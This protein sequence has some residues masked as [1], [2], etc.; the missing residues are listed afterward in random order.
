MSDATRFS[1]LAGLLLS[2]PAWSAPLQITID[3][4]QVMHDGQPKAAIGYNG[5]TPGPVLHLDEGEDAV[6]QVT[7][8]LK[9]TTSIHWHGMILPFTQDGVPGFG[10]AGIAPGETFTYRFP[11][12]QNGTFWYHSHSGMQEQE[13]AYG[14]I[15]IKPKKREPFRYDRDYVVL[16]SDRHRDSGETIF[17]HL[18]AAA[19]YYNQQQSTLSDLFADMRSKGVW[20][21]LK[22]RWM[23]GDMRMSPN[24]ISDVQGYR[25]LL[26]GKT[27]DEDWRAGFN[28]GERIRLRLVNASAMTY[29]DVR[30]PGL[31]MTVVQADGTNVQPVLVDELRLAVAETYD[32]IVQPETAQAYRIFAETMARDGFASGSLSPR[33]DLVA[34]MPALRPKPELTMADM[35]MGSMDHDMAGMDHDMTGMSGMDHDM[36]NMDMANMSGMDHD[37]S[38]MTPA[39]DPFYAPGSG[40]TPQA[41][42][43]GKFLSYTDLKVQKPRYAFR[44]ATREIELRLTGNMERYSWSINGIKYEDAEPLRL[45]Y[46]ER[47][48][49]KF[50]NDTMMTHPMHL[51]GMWTHLDTG[52]GKWNPV[53]HVVSIAPATTVYTEVEVDAPGEWAFHCHLMYHMMGGMFRKVIVE[54]APESAAALSAPWQEVPLQKAPLQKQQQAQRGIL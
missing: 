6:I 34:P 49:F 16:F 38:Q 47:V 32:V 45:Q 17:N 27:P 21:T 30:I 37:M 18:K 52:S 11:V 14:A 24:D 44:P 46:G 13:G 48:R 9:E 54:G 50:V 8:N 10:F 43:D 40:L 36:T 12:K 1:L 51:H 23:W 15:V 33:A 19:D 5:Q 41:A 31:K 7:N 35:S 42:D 29:F 3:P 25:Y 53:K 39:R 20:A 4:I 26:N 28:P 2:A 22:D